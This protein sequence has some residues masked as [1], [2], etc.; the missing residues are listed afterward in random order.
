MRPDRATG[1]ARSGGCAVAGAAGSGLMAE[2]S[3]RPAQT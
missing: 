1:A 3:T 2:S